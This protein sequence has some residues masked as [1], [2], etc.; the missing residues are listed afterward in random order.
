[1]NRDF[2]TEWSDWLRENGP[3][4]MLYSRQ[5]SRCEADAE[6]VLQ[7]ALVKTWKTHTVAPDKKVISLAYTNVRR[8]AI[9]LA[10]SMDRRTAREQKVVETGETVSWFKLPEDD[11]NRAL[12]VALAKIPESFREVVTL[13]IWGEQTFAEIGQSLNISPNTAASRY[14]YGLDA[15]RKQISREQI[16]LS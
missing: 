11:E 12:Q 6:D 15:L 8:C 5:Q 14:R 4:L 3:R 13:K 7:A 1:M 16:H 9:D 10:R 2:S